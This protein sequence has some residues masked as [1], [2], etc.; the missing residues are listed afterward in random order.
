METALLQVV[1]DGRKAR[2]EV[3]GISTE[4]NATADAADKA[5]ERGQKS[6]NNLAT[7]A[8]VVKSKSSDLKKEMDA[9]EKETIAW[10]QATARLMVAQ[11][12]LSGAVNTLQFSLAGARNQTTQLITAQTQLALIQA[13]MR[14]AGGGTGSGGLPGV[15]ATGGSGAGSVAAATRD[16]LA[17]LAAYISV[18]QAIR[19][20]DELLRV[21]ILFEN[22]D[23]SLIAVTGSAP[24]AA[25]ELEFLREET[26]RL[27]LNLEKTIPEFVKITAAFG[28]AGFS[29]KESEKIFTDVSIATRALG[30]STATTNRV[31]YDMQEMASLG[32]VQMRQFRQMIMQM[33][34][35]MDVAARA[36]GTTTEEFHKLL[37]DGL[38]PAKEFL[39][40]LAAEFAKTFGTASEQSIQSTESAVNRLKNAWLELKSAVAEGVYFKT[41]I[42]GG[43]A[44]LDEQRYKMEAARMQ[45]TAAAQV[46]DNSAH[47]NIFLEIFAPDNKRIEAEAERIQK[48]NAVLDKMLQEKFPHFPDQTPFYKSNQSFTD[49]YQERSMSAASDREIFDAR[50]KVQEGYALFGEGGGA[51]SGGGGG[52]GPASDEAI[53]NWEKAIQLQDKFYAQSEQG[54]DKQIA[55]IERNAAKEKTALDEL[56]S[57]PPFSVF[58]PGKGYDRSGQAAFEDAFGSP[59]DALDNATA[60]QINAA[61]KAA[62]DKAGREFFEGE[63]QLQKLRD[64]IDAKAQPDKRLQELAAVHLQYG[65]FRQDLD[66]LNVAHGVELEYYEKLDAAEQSATKE[67][68]ARFEK[69]FVGEGTL[70]ELLHRRLELEKELLSINE[71]DPTGGA[72]AQKIQNEMR[73]LERQNALKEQTGSAGPAESFI[74]GWDLALQKYGT[75][76]KGITKLSE[77]TADSMTNNVSGAFVS[78]ATGAQT[79]QQAFS[80]M[81]QSMLNE[82]TQL[83]AKLLVMQGIKALSSVF[84]GGTGGGTGAISGI[85][86]GG[87]AFVDQGHM[88]GVVGR[89]GGGGSVSAMI[90]A[91]AH[92]YHN[93]GIVGDEQPIIAR[94]GEGVFTPEQMAAIGQ[95]KGR[96]QKVEIINVTDP[97]MID[98][99]LAQNPNAILNVLARNRSTLRRLFT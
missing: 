10:A 31:L 90:F 36:A 83:I 26:N 25:Q 43:A 17:Y 98:E 96:A 1:L 48:V 56:F 3:K 51:G 87:G 80:K 73:A 77:Q 95:S 23:L 40:L 53:A 68:E 62:Q 61:K 55:D 63:D 79:A 42:E 27:G 88:G 15:G 89:L 16:L 9:A 54:L 76:S 19:G 66:A 24:K 33:P 32:T 49:A 18:R 72:R 52:T 34:G 29:F 75:I 50:R 85:T 6:L 71:N 11:G 99:Y 46:P 81:T 39:P 65:I 78:W 92:R 94:R 84:G 4:L 35:G 97:R 57:K 22:L 64:E 37:H 13:Q 67:I 82:L 60:N 38:I 2:E 93:G 14:A 47:R 30:L 69:T 74:Y 45:Q 86:E 70:S 8:G 41:T 5:S 20:G 44:F 7:A 58:H 91:G 28:Q 59:Y 21:K 12:N